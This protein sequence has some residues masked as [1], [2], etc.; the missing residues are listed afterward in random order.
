VILIG[1]IAA[2]AGLLIALRLPRL[3]Q[4]VFEIDGFERASIDRYWVIV[5]L[6]T[7]GEIARL[8]GALEPMQPIRIVHMTAEQ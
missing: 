6:K 7:N 3:W 4:P 5:G 2:F 8:T 1:G